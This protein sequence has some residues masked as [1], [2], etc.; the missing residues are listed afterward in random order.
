M[1]I[2]T[3][4]YLLCFRQQITEQ[5]TLCIPFVFAMEVVEAVDLAMLGMES[6]GKISI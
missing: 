2:N 3:L 6:Q 1:L 4:I 5:F